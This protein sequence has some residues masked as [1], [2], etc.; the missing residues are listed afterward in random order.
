MSFFSSLFGAAVQKHD[1]IKILDKEAFQNAI[2]HHNVQL[3]DVRTPQEYQGGYLKNAINIDY[4]DALNFTLTFEKLNKQKPVYLY[5]RSG[6]RSQKAAAKLVEMGFTK[7]YD[8]KGGYM[9]W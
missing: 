3:V 8:L 6:N 7:I 1:A 4:F 9:N 5:C 2:E